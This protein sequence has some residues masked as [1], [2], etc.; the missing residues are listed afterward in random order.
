MRAVNLLPKNQPKNRR[1]RKTTPWALVVGLAGV[2][3]VS[4]AIGALF[5][6]ASGTASDRQAELADVSAQLAALP[7]PKPVPNSDTQL[8][9]ERDQRAS[10]VA[11]AFAYSVAWDRVLRRMALVLPDDVWLTSL[12]AQAPLAVG[13]GPRGL[14]SSALPSGITLMGYT[15]SHAGVARLLSRLSVLPDLTNVTLQMSQ[16]V[17][18]D[19]RQLVTFTIV[20][21]VK[22]GRDGLMKPAKKS[23]SQPMQ[24]TLAGLAI[25][26]LAA[27]G[28]FMLIKPK[29]AE[30]ARTTVQIAAVRKEID[31]RREASTARQAR[32]AVKTA[33]LFKLAKVMPADEDMAATLLE[34][35]QV[36]A[37]AG[38]VFESITPAV[39]VGADGFR[40]IP[41]ALVFRG[42]FYTLSDFLFR[43]RQ[44]VQVRGGELNA[45]GQLFSVDTLRFAEDED[46]KFP[47]IRAELVVDSFVYGGL[48]A[49][50]GV[51]G[52]ATDQ[53][54]TE[55]TSTET[56]QTQTTPTTPEPAPAGPSGANASAD[57]G[58][59]LL[60]AAKKQSVK[61]QK[62][63][64]QKIILIAG[65][66][67]LAV[68]LLIQAPRILSIVHG[69]GGE[70]AAA[71]YKAFP[72]AVLSAGHP[73]AVA[74]STSGAVVLPEADPDPEP[75]AGQLVDFAL[76]PSKDPFVQ[77]VKEREDEARA[78]RPPTCPRRR[79]AA[80]RRRRAAARAARRGSTAA[81]AALRSRPRRRRP[82]SPST[83]TRR[84]SRSAASSRATTRRSSSSRRRIRRRGSASPA[85]RSQAATRRSRSAAA[86]R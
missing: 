6:S 38:I 16:L 9:G 56:T 43:L 23:M 83:A 31:D 17:E 5:L 73:E 32:V 79:A 29:R 69:G 18:L 60:M 74:V 12:D 81:V 40:A 75:G 49:P 66:A 11:S 80:V 36:A 61:E 10:A 41:I 76:F 82:P 22:S 46:K 3:V 7:K 20:G 47:F 65:G 19:G 25:V 67:L 52:T 72:D 70:S 53:T 37:D 14:G 35:N 68:I 39:P 42:N 28:W 71:P 77:Q 8:T 62:A 15:Y 86:T 85:A 78:L 57:D 51:P 50:A 27:A 59:L 1:R 24:F 21:D 34:L 64:K 54:S 26:V 58:A 2:A 63:R 44:L 13:I 30:A 55:P 48:P 33:D 84:T 45:T 4:A